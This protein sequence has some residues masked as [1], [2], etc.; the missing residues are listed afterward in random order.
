LA[1]AISSSRDAY[2]DGT[3]WPSAS[4]WVRAHEDEKPMPPASSPSCRRRSIAASSS[5]VASRVVDSAPMTIRR[6]AEWPTMN[7]ALTPSRPD[8]ASR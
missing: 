3:M 6:I 1:N 2:R 7:P 4:L 8:T 5:A